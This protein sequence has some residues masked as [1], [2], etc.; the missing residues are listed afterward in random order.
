MKFGRTIFIC[1]FVLFWTSESLLAAN[2]GQTASVEMIDD[3]INSLDTTIHTISKTRPEQL[4]KELNVTRQQVEEKLLALTAL[5]SA[6]VG[7]KNALAGLEKSEK[8]LE[9]SQQIYEDFNTRGMAK[10]PPYSLTFHDSILAEMSTATRNKQNTQLA[11]EMLQKN[12]D[13]YTDQLAQKES[14]FR[15]LKEKLGT[16]SSLQTPENLLKIDLMALPVE[17]L[18]TMLQAFG[19]AAKQYE[20]ET[21]NADIQI[22]QLTAQEQFVGSNIHHDKEDLDHQLE[23]IQKKETDIQK[24]IIRF[25]NDQDAVEK[26]WTT[27]QQAINK[28]QT[29]QERNLAQAYLKS[30][31]EWRKTYI[32]ALNL[33]QES[34]KLLNRQKKIWQLRY[35]MV[36]EPLAFDQQK[37]IID[38]A[39]KSLSNLNQT[40]LIQQNHLINLQKQIS[41]IENL[42][43]EAGTSLPVITHL[44]IEKSA[45]GRQ[46]ERRLEFQSIIIGTDQ[47][48]QNLLAQ[49]KKF[50]DTPTVKENFF[51]IT[52]IIK[53]IWNL[54]IWVVDQNSMSVGKV[55]T[56]LIILVT[57]L[58]LAKFIVHLIHIKLLASSQLKET[59]ASAVHKSL[60]YFAYLMVFL[61]VL[62]IVNIPLT[63]F[64]FLGGAIAIGVGFGAQNLI[65]N[66]ISGF[67]IL[68]E[69]PINIGDLIEV[70]GILG[71]VEE[72]GA[73]CT[74]VRTG[75]NIHKLIPN[76]SFLEKNIT[77]WTLS[78]NR[79]R[80]KIVIGV[81]YGS[82]VK[83]VEAALIKSVLAN[84]KILKSPGPLVL[85][86]DFGDNSLI[87]E[88]YF[89]VVIRMILEKKQIESQVRFEIDAVFR[90]EGIVIAFPQRDLHFD[91][92]KPLSIQ[93]MGNPFAPKP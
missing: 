65:N 3:R 43:Q 69:R 62:R 41:A 72:I 42:L 51:Q 12:I 17:R 53:E 73:R 58:F 75:E 27:A 28:A 89:W 91:A 90:E 79:I 34:L 84:E 25:K 52:Q 32:V 93:L 2:L 71:K 10:K 6:Y 57:G 50:M 88:V 33:K 35:A 19:V 23:L 13:D 55:F 40:L 49:T 77:N 92:N 44:G 36:K 56:A 87:F 30:R 82:S 15:Q 37:Q 5:H 54:E 86:S 59:T 60:S 74:R 70:D 26:E 81:A 21:R 61:L 9:T 63:A 31:D 14:D 67:I 64:A 24:E 4:A 1:F 38:E 8:E 11:L 29:E 48:E 47:S 18:K 68:G 39:E 66:F 78:D 46:F 16:P 85:F 45:L 83:T 76:S 80:T 7:L 20:I 22:K